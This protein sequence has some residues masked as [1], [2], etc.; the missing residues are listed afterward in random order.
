MGPGQSLSLMQLGPTDRL[1]PVQGLVHRLLRR[2]VPGVQSSTCCDNKWTF[3]NLLN[4]YIYSM[5][6]IYMYIYSR[7]FMIYRN[8]MKYIGCY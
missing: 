2:V 6:I 8:I 3:E 5:W 4:I 1:D 7:C